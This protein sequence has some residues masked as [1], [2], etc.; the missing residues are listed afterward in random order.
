M[1]LISLG[2]L[3]VGLFTANDTLF[4]ASGLF[5]IASSIDNFWYGYFKNKNKNS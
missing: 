2:L 1:F 4:I 5:G 3:I